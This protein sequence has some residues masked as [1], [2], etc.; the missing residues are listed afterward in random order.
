[1]Q[2]VLFYT[3]IDE[4]YVVYAG[5]DKHENEELL[6]YGWDE[7]VWFHVDKLSSAHIY[8]RLKDGVTIDT[9]P[10]KVSTPWN[11][12]LATFPGS[13]SKLC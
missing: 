7:D 5:R 12:V 11:A 10:E 2:M 1:M 4:S 6:K 9:I 13:D 3:T 8:L